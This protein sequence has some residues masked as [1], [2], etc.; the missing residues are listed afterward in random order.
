MDYIYYHFKTNSL[1][2]KWSTAEIETFLYGCGLFSKDE[3]QGAFTSKKPFISISLMNVC[4]Y[5]SWNSEEYDSDN[6]NFISIVT[7][8]NWYWG[9]NKNAQIQAIFDGF[10]NLLHTKIQEDC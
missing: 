8:D 7:S 4:N 9:I 5:D 3:K 1:S 2:E 10:E 6:T